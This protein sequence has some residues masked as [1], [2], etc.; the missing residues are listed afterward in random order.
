MSFDG[1]NREAVLGQGANPNM[2]ALQGAL[3]QWSLHGKKATL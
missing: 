2:L 1:L 3:G